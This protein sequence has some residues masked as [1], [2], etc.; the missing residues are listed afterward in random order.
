MNKTTAIDSS[1]SSHSVA[2]VLAVLVASIAT[3]PNA[4]SSIDSVATLH[5]CADPLFPHLL[6]RSMLGWTRIAFAVFI[7]IVSVYRITQ[8]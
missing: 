3:I 8:S 5:N 4:L 2:F 6:S 7:F 1:P